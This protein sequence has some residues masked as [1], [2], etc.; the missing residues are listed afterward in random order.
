MHDC[1]VF[2]DG[3]VRCWGDQLYGQLGNGIDST[4]RATTPQLAKLCP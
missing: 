3:A 2:A 1:A 4:A